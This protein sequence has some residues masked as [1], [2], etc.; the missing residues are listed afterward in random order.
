MVQLA[1]SLFPYAYVENNMVMIQQRACCW[2]SKKVVDTLGNN[3][4]HIIFCYT[5]K[6]T[7][8]EP[9]LNTL[10]VEFWPWCSVYRLAAKI[11]RIS[12]TDSMTCVQQTD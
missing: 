8:E 5:V 7:E 10:K 11:Y 4:Q 1:S 6:T 2:G 3:G 12:S 9:S